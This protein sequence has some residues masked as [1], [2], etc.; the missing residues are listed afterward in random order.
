[1]TKPVMSCVLAMECQDFKESSYN[2]FPGSPNHT[3]L[4]KIYYCSKADIKAPFTHTLFYEL[5]RPNLGK[6]DRLFRK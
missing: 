3:R 1:M 2:R 4:Y 5:S 6:R